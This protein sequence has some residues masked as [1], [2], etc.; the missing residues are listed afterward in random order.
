M[1]ITDQLRGVYLVTTITKEEYNYRLEKITDIWKKKMN[2]DTIKRN[3][4]FCGKQI[5]IKRQPWKK[6]DD[7]SILINV[8]KGEIYNVPNI[9]VESFLPES[10]ARKTHPEY[11]L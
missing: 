6:D 3:M 9:L 2:T 1:K 5:L 8:C 10:E 7:N 11:F 4:K